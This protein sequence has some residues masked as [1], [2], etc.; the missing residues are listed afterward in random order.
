MTSSCN[1]HCQIIL[2]YPAIG[3]LKCLPDPG[4]DDKLENFMATMAVG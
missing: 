1:K 3:C 2:D 4:S